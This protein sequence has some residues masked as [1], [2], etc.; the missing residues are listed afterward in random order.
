MRVF[1]FWADGGRGPADSALEPRAHILA[2]FPR[3]IVRHRLEALG[4]GGLVPHL[5]ALL[6]E[7]SNSP[8]P[9]VVA[10]LSYDA[11]RAAPGHEQ[12]F[13]RPER[14]RHHAHDGLPDLLVATY[15]GYLERDDD[16]GPW[17]A[18]GDVRAL[19]DALAH[20][21]E[22]ALPEPLA[23]GPL[24]DPASETVY[25]DGF[26]A[27][28]DG[29]A[30]GDFYQVNLARRLESAFVAP[31]AATDPPRLAATAYALYLALRE[32]QPVP[33]GALLP[34]AED[35]WLVSG[36]P[37]CLLR[38]TAQDRRARSFPIKGTVARDAERG[39]DDALRRELA[40]S[41][42]DQ[43]EHVMIVDLVR[44][45]L[46]RV[47]VTGSVH[48]PAILSELGLATV[49]HLVAEVAATLAPERDLADLVAALFPGGSITGAPKIAAMKALD[50]HEPFAR[51]FY[52]GSLG[53]V[54]GGIDASFSILIRSATLS[55][56]GLTYAAGG[57]LVADSDAERELAETRIKT[58]AIDAALA[59]I[60]GRAG[61][62]E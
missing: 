18:V 38:Y 45:D 32:A 57:G 31:L 26:E 24:A 10:L 41:L 56:D 2:A 33:F 55:V 25:R 15:D 4:P 47:A 37:E 3:Q 50:R 54:R 28:A 51:G 17:R 60:A 6:P 29:I 21:P 59:R 23:L 35:A 52:C 42:K 11:G 46:G 27:I 49:R 16:T 40:A 39:R 48:V 53:V 43:A 36:S 22:G 1:P 20:T 5:R 8:L 9:L 30:A 44:N 19:L 62:I 14:A 58:R 7:P 61:H 34:V 13:P 12:L